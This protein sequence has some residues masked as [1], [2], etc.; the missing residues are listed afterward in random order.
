MYTDQACT[1]T[2]PACGCNGFMQPDSGAGANTGWVYI[3]PSIITNKSTVAHEFFHTVQLGIAPVAMTTT[4]GNR[5]MMR[6]ASASWIGALAAGNDGGHQPIFQRAGADAVGAS[7]DFPDSSSETLYGE[8]PFFE[9]ESERFTQAVVKDDFSQ[10][11]AA[12]AGS[13]V[14]WMNAALTGRGSSL[15][16]TVADYAAKVNAADW[17]TVPPMPSSQLTGRFPFV[18]ADTVLGVA[19]NTSTNQSATLDHLATR[20]FRITS[21]ACSGQCDATLH[22]DVSWPNGSGVQASVMRFGTPAGTPIPVTNGATSTHAD[23]PFNLNTSYTVAVTNPS[24]TANAVPIALSANATTPPPATNGGTTT[25]P[26]TTTPTT[27][28]TGIPVPLPVPTLGLSGNR[29][30][31]CRAAGA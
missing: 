15:G 30:C 1:A 14:D 21:N 17:P 23:L 31:R 19:T 9:F 26:K 29:R 24:L 27:P 8:W 13:Q 2:L 4:G 5:V 16:Q 3:N 10:A 11:N 7:L 25:A 6:E 20:F 12:P 22:L 18:Q 28:N